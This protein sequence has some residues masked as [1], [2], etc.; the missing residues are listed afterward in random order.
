LQ[1]LS[2]Q[3]RWNA[4][5]SSGHP[6]AN[7]EL[8]SIVGSAVKI[9][10][11]IH[12]FTRASVRQLAGHVPSF[13]ATFRGGAYVND[14]M[15]CFPAPNQAKPLDQPQDAVSAPVH[16]LPLLAALVEAHS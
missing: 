11:H 6:K 1:N 15:G 2:Q 14:P 16:Q 13:A 4:Q 7:K 5:A 8:K 9:A 12:I 10:F 3:L